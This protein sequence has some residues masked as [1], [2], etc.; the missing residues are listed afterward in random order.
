MTTMTRRK[1]QSGETLSLGFIMD[2]VVDVFANNSDSMR[3][4]AVYSDPVFLPFP[5]NRK[6]YV[7]DSDSSLEIEVCERRILKLNFKNLYRY[8][9]F[10]IL[11]IP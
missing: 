5:K 9:H 2:G 11:L 4:I 3:S 6:T 1:R 8:M 10:R 7:V